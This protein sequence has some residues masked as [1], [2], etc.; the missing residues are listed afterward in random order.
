MLRC[1]GSAVV[2][3]FAAHDSEADDNHRA[4]DDDVYD[5]AAATVCRGGDVDID[6]PCDD[7]DDAPGDHDDTSRDHDD[8]SRDDYDASRDDDDSS[9]DDDYDAGYECSVIAGVGAVLRCVGSAVVAVFAADDGEADDDHRACDDDVYD[10]S[11]TVYWCGG[12]VDDPPRHHHD[13]PADH[14]HTSGHH[15][16]TPGDHDDASRDD[17]DASRDDDD[18]SPDD[19]YDAGCECSVVAG[20]GAVLRCVGSAVF[21]VFAADDGEADDDHRACDDDVYD[22]S[23]TV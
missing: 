18:S 19:D 13:A 2:A 21:A 12:D 22:E 14:H 6:D 9:P 4:R 8:A 7:H 17:Y 16:V 15:H 11:A 20:V 3:V 10:E 5:G 23:A 1:V